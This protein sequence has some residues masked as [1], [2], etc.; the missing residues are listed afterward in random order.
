[1]S[2]SNKLIIFPTTSDKSTS[3]G[4]TTTSKGVTTTGKGVTTTSKGV[5]TTGKGVTTKSPPQKRII[6]STTQ[7]KIQDPKELDPEYQ[8]T[9]IREMVAMISPESKMQQF[10]RQQIHQKIY[11]YKSQDLAK[12]LFQQDIFITIESILQKM[13]DCENHCY[14]CKKMVQVLYEYVREPNQWTLERLDNTI[15]HTCEN[16]VIACLHCN[17]RRRTMYHERYLFTKELE[18]KKV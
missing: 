14:Y 10:I 11:G 1:M 7:W 4:V 12:H 9:I 16:V 13:V 5:S 3:K 2:N 15:G 17:L 6:T 18:I 8:L